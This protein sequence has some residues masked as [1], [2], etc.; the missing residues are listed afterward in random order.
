MASASTSGAR[1]ADASSTLDARSLA[2]SSRGSE[3][4]SATA[5]KGSRADTAAETSAGMRRSARKGWRE[6]RRGGRLFAMMDVVA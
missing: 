2:L 6:E 4:L 5:A 1:P 3:G